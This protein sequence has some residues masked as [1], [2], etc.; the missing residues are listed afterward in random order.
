MLVVVV[1]FTLISFFKSAHAKYFYNVQTFTYTFAKLAFSFSIYLMVVAFLV[2]NIVLKFIT[3]TI[4]FS[5]YLT[6]YV[7][8]VMAIS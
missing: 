2:Q 1:Y 3:F 5:R 8:L 4:L 7:P 6:C